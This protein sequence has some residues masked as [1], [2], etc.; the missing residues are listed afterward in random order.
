MTLH[1]D[2]G[3]PTLHDARLGT[4]PPPHLRPRCSSGPGGSASLGGPDTPRPPA[5]W[6]PTEGP[7][8]VSPRRAGVR[9]A[10]APLNAAIIKEHRS[11]ARGPSLHRGVT[12]RASPA[13]PWALTAFA[14]RFK[15]V[16]RC[17]APRPRRAALPQRWAKPPGGADVGWGF[18]APRGLNCPRRPSIAR[19]A[20]LGP[21]P[22]GGAAGSRL[23]A[24]LRDRRC[25]P[26]AARPCAPVRA[27]LPPPAGGGGAGRS[28]RN[29]AAERPREG[30][31]KGGRCG[32]ALGPRGATHTPCGLHRGRRS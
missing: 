14:R 25:P 5:E 21:G 8:S 15:G 19:R 32:K 2:T 4:C 23:L 7:P 6:G 22:R 18:A 10:P 26:A 31:R 28:V 17:Y 30:E 1:G 11:A 20:S 27:A 3:T 9:F 13:A 12:V 29:P 24:G 16:E